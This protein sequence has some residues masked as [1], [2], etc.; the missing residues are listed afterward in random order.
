MALN[1]TVISFKSSQLTSISQVKGGTSHFRS[2]PCQ[3]A[4]SLLLLLFSF[5]NFNSSS[6]GLSSQKSHNIFELS[7][8]IISPPEVQDKVLTKIRT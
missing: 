2:K 5:L 8:Q 7:S 6:Y 1:L 4:K 3:L